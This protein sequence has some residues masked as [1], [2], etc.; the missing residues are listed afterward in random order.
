MSGM[1]GSLSTAGAKR[2]V[3]RELALVADLA[4][5]AGDEDRWVAIIDRVYAVLDG[6]DDGRPIAEVT[7]APCPYPAEWV[8]DRDRCRTMIAGTSDDAVPGWVNFAQLGDS[9]AP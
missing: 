3:A 5:W 8:G 1:A 2:L 7:R 9:A 4:A 6:L